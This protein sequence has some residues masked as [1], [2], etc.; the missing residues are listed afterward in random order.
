[1]NEVPTDVIGKMVVVSDGPVVKEN[2]RVCPYR[3]RRR[4]FL[5]GQCLRDGSP[6]GRGR[7]VVGTVYLPGRCMGVFGLS[8]VVVST[9]AMA[10][11]ASPADFAGAVAPADLAGTDVPAVAGKKFS[12]VAEVYSSADDDEGAPLVIRASK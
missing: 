2:A 6:L 10:G 11:A 12:A 3:L 5:S 9:T 8:D 1:M 7:T 4:S